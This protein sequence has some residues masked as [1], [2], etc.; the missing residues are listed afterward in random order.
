MGEER[1]KNFSIYA[2]FFLRIDCFLIVYHLVITAGFFRLDPRGVVFVLKLCTRRNEIFIALRGVSR[3]GEKSNINNSV[4]N[5][6]P[7]P[8][9]RR[10][11]FETG[12]EWEGFIC[13]VQALIAGKEMLKV[14]RY[15]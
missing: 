5:R 10:M 8:F 15:G 7:F 11:F 12:R 3:S 4:G 9:V 6:Y 14:S 1:D 2:V 13:P